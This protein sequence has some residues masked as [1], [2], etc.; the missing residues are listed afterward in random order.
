MKRI[1]LALLILSLISACM[2]YETPSLDES[3][4]P[5]KQ[6]LTLPIEG[7]IQEI[8]VSDTWIAIHTLDKIIAIDI[9]TQKT[10]W[11]R[12]FSVIT[13][14]EGFLMNG[15]TLVAAS[16]DQ[17]VLMGKLGEEKVI[18][19]DPGG[20]SITKLVAVYP[21][22][23]YVI[24]DPKWTLEAYDISKN[25][26]LWKTIV[27]RGGADEVFYG[28]PNNIAYVSGG[29]VRA[30]DNSTGA[31]L[32][33]QKGNV[34]RSAFDA[35]VLYIFEEMNGDDNYRFAAIDVENQK[36]LWEKDIII[37]SSSSVYK[38][39]II[40]DLLIASTNDLIA[41]DKYTG[42]QVWKTGV[43]YTFYTSPVEFNGIIYA[44][45]GSNR[46]VYA[47]SPS[48]GSVTGY[49]RLENVSL[50][51]GEN[52]TDSVYKLEDGIAINTKN[53]VVIYKKK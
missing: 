9:D 10:L 36:E 52:I 26:L 34:W 40:D 14:G 28:S 18:N 37:P 45:A 22:Y 16:L 42:Q 20:G 39:T 41:M 46:A 51:D 21:N 50:F 35:G 27:G 13:Y 38:L 24:R 44:K 53:A 47:I 8:A 4:F 7:D 6:F 31:L 3:T 5:L 48:D 33:E 19:L 25:I 2:I 12:N 15:D 1:A 11:S 32:W 29:P 23:L 49:A 43:G 30:F 17:I